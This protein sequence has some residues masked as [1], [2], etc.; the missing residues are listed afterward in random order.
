[1]SIVYSIGNVFVARRVTGLPIMPWSKD[2]AAPLIVCGVLCAAF[3][4]LPQC[5]MGMSFFRLVVTTM[6][7]LVLFLPVSWMWVLKQ[8]ERDFVKAKIRDRIMRM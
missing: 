4:Y 7:F 2:V 5:F 3:A 1:M 6:V 8:E